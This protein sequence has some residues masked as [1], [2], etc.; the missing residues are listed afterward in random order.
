LKSFPK[1]I[2]VNIFV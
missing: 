2:L 1:E